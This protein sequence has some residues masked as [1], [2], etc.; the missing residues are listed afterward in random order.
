MRT[1]IGVTCR[2]SATAECPAVAIRRSSFLRFSG[3]T[4]A[5]LTVRDGH[6]SGEAGLLSERC[7]KLAG[8]VGF[9]RPLGLPVQLHD[10]R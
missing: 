6:A 8:R 2:C 10:T 5:R 4:A 3:F 7:D 1:S 9:R